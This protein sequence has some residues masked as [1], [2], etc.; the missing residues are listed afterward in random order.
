MAAVPHTCYNCGHVGHFAKECTTPRQIDVPRHQG[1]SN[2]PPRVV[3]AKTGR[4]N[5][6]TMEDVLEGGHVLASTF[7]LNGHPIVILF[8]S[9]ATHDFIS[10]AYTQKHKLVVKNI[11]TSYMIHT[12]VENVFTKQLAMSTPLNL[13]GKIY[14]THQIILDGQ[15]IDVIMGMSWMRDHKALL[16]IAACTVQLDSPVHGIMI[17]QLSSVIE[18]PQK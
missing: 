7:S 13:A 4:V 18:P 5:Y 9:G 6:T 8:D 10:K 15:G 14:R 16:D 11:D 12:M 2:H 3:A 17:L 1:Y